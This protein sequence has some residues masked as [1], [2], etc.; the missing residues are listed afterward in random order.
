[1]FGFSDR[2]AVYAEGWRYGVIDTKG[3]ILVSGYEFIRPFSEGLAAVLS[4]GRWGFIDT[5]GK[6]VIKPRFGDVRNVP[7]PFSEGFAAVK[8]RD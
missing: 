6:E 7:S 8:M 5:Q 3:Q 4:G 2:R 1:M